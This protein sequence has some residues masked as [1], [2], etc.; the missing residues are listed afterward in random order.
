MLKNLLKISIRIIKGDLLYSL[1]NILGLTIG[2][3]SSLFLLLHIFDELSY[4]KFHVDAIR[5]E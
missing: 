1:L 5:N 2:F 3:T 4:E